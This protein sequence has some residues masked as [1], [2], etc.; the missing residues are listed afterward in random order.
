MFGVCDYLCGEKSQAAHGH[1]SVVSLTWQM[2]WVVLLDKASFPLGGGEEQ[3]AAATVGALLC[4]QLGG[5]VEGEEGFKM[6]RP[7]LSTILI[8][9]CASLSAR[10][11]VSVATKCP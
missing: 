9:S 6:L 11:S 4:V 1:I 8:D 3:A 10:Q 5:G 7:I 2:N